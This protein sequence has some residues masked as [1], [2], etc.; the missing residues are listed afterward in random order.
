M[1]HRLMPFLAA[2]IPSSRWVLFI[3]LLGVVLAGLASRTRSRASPAGQHSA[4]GGRG[5]LRSW[6]VVLA[7]GVVG[8]VLIALVVVIATKKHASGEFPPVAPRRPC[9][10]WR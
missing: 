4:H 5:P 3:P 9:C 6:Q 8:I 2:P 10:C 7:A 1:N